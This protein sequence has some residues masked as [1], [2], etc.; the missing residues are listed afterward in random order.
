MENPDVDFILK[1]DDFDNA[2]SSDY[3]FNENN[4]KTDGLMCR[5]YDDIRYHKNN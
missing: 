2:M 3:N 1:I 4:C 5:T